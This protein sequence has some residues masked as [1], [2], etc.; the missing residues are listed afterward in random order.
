MEQDN[1]W[2]LHPNGC[3]ITRDGRIRRNGNPLIMSGLYLDEN[4]KRVLVAVKK[5]MKEL[6]KNVE[7]PTLKSLTE[8]VK[9]IEPEEIWKPV[10]GFKDSGLQIS[11]KGNVKDRDEFFDKSLFTGN[12]ILICQD[13][14]C[15]ELGRKVLILF[16]GDRRD[17]NCKRQIGYKDGDHTNCTLENLVLSKEKIKEGLLIEKEVIDS[18]RL[19]YRE[20]QE[21]NQSLN[22][23]IIVLKNKLKLDVPIKSVI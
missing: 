5:M 17:K 20:L 9:L 15:F 10:P 3:E 4:G 11:N 14:K 19:A 23:E 7:L 2:Y 8:P 12:P 21:K 18:M 22:K 6:F 13:E 16:S 1:E